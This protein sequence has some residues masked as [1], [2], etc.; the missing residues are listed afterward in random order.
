VKEVRARDSVANPKCAE[1]ACTVTLIP[2]THCNDDSLHVRA[3]A[4]LR[5]NNSM[6]TC[7]LTS[8]QC[9]S[10]CSM[11]CNHEIITHDHTRTDSVE[12]VDVQAASESTVEKYRYRLFVRIELTISACTSRLS[13]SETRQEFESVCGSLKFCARLIGLTSEACSI[14]APPEARLTPVEH[15]P[16]RALR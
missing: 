14:N 1:R 5:S 7:L 12:T 10:P 11:L 4:V 15:A 3:G 9:W 6:Y 16:M 8:V 2:V 13:E